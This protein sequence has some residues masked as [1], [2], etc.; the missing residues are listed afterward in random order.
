VDRTGPHAQLFA[1]IRVPVEVLSG[2]ETF[3]EML[4]A[5]DSIMAAIPGATQ[6]RMRG[7]GHTWDP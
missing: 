3:T 1:N 2:E 5:A 7:A 4:T 6:K